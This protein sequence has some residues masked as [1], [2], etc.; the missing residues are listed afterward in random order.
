MSE[1]LSLRRWATGWA[2][3]LDAKK[4]RSVSESGR[5][6]QI[7]ID[8]TRSA[9]AV[10]QHLDAQSTPPALLGRASALAASS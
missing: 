7:L 8:E 6:Q 1:G 10:K 5:R 9:K 3:K 2:M 4:R